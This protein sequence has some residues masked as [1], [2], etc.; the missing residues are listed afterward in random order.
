MSNVAIVQEGFNREDPLSTLKV[1]TQPI[2]KASPGQV[3]VRVTLR[4]ILPLDFLTLR[5]SGVHNGTPGCEGF[6][7]VHEVGE[8]VK[9]FHKGQRVI[10]HTAFASLEGKGSW[11]HYVS[12]AEEWVWPVPDEMS[13]EQGAQ[14]V[15]NP[16]TAYMI[17]K[18]LQPVP[19]GEYI[20]QTAA[21]STLGKQVISL[22]NHYG[23]QLIN[24]VR[25]P[26]QRAELKALGAHDEVICSVEEDVV[27]RVKEITAGRGAWAA[28]DAVAGDMTQTLA[29]S[30]QEG[31][32]VF[33]YGVLGGFSSTVNVV[34]LFRSVSV[35]GFNNWN[36]LKD[37]EKREACAAEVAPLVISG[38][39]PFAEVEKYDL[40]DFKLAMERAEERGLSRKVLLVG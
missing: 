13:D 21:G 37:F 22:A 11:Q 3:V 18:K 25:R 35:T 5:G 26:E 2:P 40:T 34:D 14:F 28:L 31:G 10:P 38:V 32:L 24:I 8:G 15:I 6:G 30:L 9:K 33:V 20:I 36:I 27:A 19:K 12:L 1:V 23:I 17:L 7:F 4:S 29:S 16:W 39:I